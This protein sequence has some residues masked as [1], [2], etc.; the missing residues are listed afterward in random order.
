MENSVIAETAKAMRVIV[1]VPQIMA[2]YVPTRNQ[3]PKMSSLYEFF[4]RLGIFESINLFV[5][6]NAERV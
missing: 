1:L 4:R 3:I 6:S 2:S 5:L